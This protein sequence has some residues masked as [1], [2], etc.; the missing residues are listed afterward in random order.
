MEADFSNAKDARD[1]RGLIRVWESGAFIVVSRG[2]FRA[3]R[4]ARD[5]WVDGFLPG[6]AG[7]T[8]A[9]PLVLSFCRAARGGE[10]VGENLR[11]E[12]SDFKEGWRLRITWIFFDA[13]DGKL[14]FEVMEEKRASVCSFSWA[15]PRVANGPAFLLGLLSVALLGLCFRACAKVWISPEG[16]KTS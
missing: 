13:R 6:V 16:K 5:G 11:F 3:P 9:T 12:I 1:K 2:S 4:C 15:L 10:C 8:C 14:L 7:L